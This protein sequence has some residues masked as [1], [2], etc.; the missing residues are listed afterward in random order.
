MLLPALTQQLRYRYLS[1]PN[2]FNPRAS[3]TPF[4]STTPQGFDI[5]VSSLSLP[6]SPQFGIIFLGVCCR[7]ALSPVIADPPSKPC[8]LLSSPALCSASTMRRK[9]WKQVC[10]AYIWLA[11]RGERKLVAWVCAPTSNRWP[12]RSRNPALL[13]S[14]VHEVLPRL[15]ESVDGGS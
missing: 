11:R 15:L 4:L 10:M 6:Q 13:V 8:V 9:D 5:T 12:A 14:C 3:L 1:E 2:D 7:V